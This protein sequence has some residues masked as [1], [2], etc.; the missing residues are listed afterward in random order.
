MC[1]NRVQQQVS[2][3]KMIEHVHECVYVCFSLGQ[4]HLILWLCAA[5]TLKVG[6]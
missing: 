2:Q 4:V 3:V 1:L 6:A 5:E